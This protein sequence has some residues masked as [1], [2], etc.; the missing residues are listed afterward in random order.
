[1]LSNDVIKY[2]NK[3]TTQPLIIQKI[4]ARLSFDCIKTVTGIDRAGRDK[5]P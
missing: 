4:G 5:I 2:E 3:S 1:M